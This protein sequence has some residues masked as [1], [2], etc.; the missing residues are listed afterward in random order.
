MDVNSNALVISQSVQALDRNSSAG[1]NFLFVLLINLPLV[2]LYDR[3][4]YEFI[5]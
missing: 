4:Y 3:L 1:Y 5:E 2:A